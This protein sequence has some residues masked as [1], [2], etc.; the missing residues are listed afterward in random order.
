M[1]NRTDEVSKLYKKKKKKKK[2]FQAEYA[3]WTA[4]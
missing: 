3:D 1:K 2:K 4:G